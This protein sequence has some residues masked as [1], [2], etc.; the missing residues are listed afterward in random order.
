M[1]ARRRGAVEFAVDRLAGNINF[2]AVIHKGG[3]GPA[4]T[5]IGAAA[6]ATG[7]RPPR[8]DHGS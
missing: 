5:V 6:E 1:N 2:C 8:K 3:Y 4:D 7:R